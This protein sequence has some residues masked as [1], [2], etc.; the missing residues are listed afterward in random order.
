MKKVI[1]AFILVLLIVALLSACG[2][3]ASHAVKLNEKSSQLCDFTV[4][5]DQVNVTCILAINNQTGEEKKIR[6]T[7]ISTED[8]AVGLLQS[9][10]L[11]GFD[12][13]SGSDVFV[14]PKGETTITVV[15]IGQFGGTE[16]KCDRLIPD[17]I[18][19]DIIG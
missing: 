3:D 12:T 5:N 16:K 17:E 18:T 4:E 11:T 1:D 6:I 7:A 15:F 13:D 10:E 2:D 9:P 14:L 19:I 8:V